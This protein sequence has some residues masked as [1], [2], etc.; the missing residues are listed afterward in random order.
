MI[1]MSPVKHGCSVC[2]LYKNYVH[3]NLPEDCELDRNAGI[4]PR[5]ILA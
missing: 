1:H 2:Q 3:G 4:L 5:L